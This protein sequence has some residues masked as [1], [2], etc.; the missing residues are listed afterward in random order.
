[1]IS[2]Q[3]CGHTSRSSLVRPFPPIARRGGSHKADDS[4]LPPS[5]H[6]PPPIEGAFLLF[7][8]KFRLFESCACNPMQHLHL[9]AYGISC[10]TDV[11]SALFQSHEDLNMNAISR[12]H[13]RQRLNVP[14]ALPR[15]LVTMRDRL[16]NRLVWTLKPRMMPPLPHRERSTKLPQKPHG[17][18]LTQGRQHEHK[19]QTRCKSG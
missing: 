18:S 7:Y 16:G 11:S 19:H 5:P 1:V 12:C 17:T 8:S 13:A 3:N 14:G 4:V 15:A 10:G 2:L 6:T 9:M